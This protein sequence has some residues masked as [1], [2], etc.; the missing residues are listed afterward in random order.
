MKTNTYVVTVFFLLVTFTCA[1]FLEKSF[2]QVK[3][4]TSRQPVPHNGI[5]EGEFHFKRVAPAR[6]QGMSH[7]GKGWSKQAHLLWDG[8]VGDACKL[9]FHVLY[10]SEYDLKLQLTLAPDYGKFRVLLDGKILSKS[11]DTYSGRVEL[12]ERLELG[13]QKLKAGTHEL[14]FELTG[15]N[16]KAVHFRKDRYL[17]GLDYLQLTNL[18]PNTKAKVIAARPKS[19]VL[20][21]QQFQSF[22]KKNCVRCH[23]VEK[24]EAEL[25]LRVY[26]SIKNLEDDLETTHLIADAIEKKEMPPKDVQPKPLEKER[27]QAVNFLKNI[28][29]EKLQKSNELP[30]VVMRRLNRLEY[31]NAVRDLLNLKGGHLS[32]S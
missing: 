23:G 2:G 5:Y 19:N 14:V 27:V 22:L 16:E 18:D 30:I 32:P 12:A 24:E 15:A 4:R 1:L 21:N 28:M 9:R 11:V 6:V 3:A 8:K 29:D 13:K 31:S 25:D 7:Y 20:T 26:K 10:E 17:L